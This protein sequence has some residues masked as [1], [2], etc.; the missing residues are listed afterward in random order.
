MGQDI[1]YLPYVTP[2]SAKIGWQ[3]CETAQKVNQ[4]NSRDSTNVVRAD[5][6]NQLRPSSSG[7][8][9]RPLPVCAPARPLSAALLPPAFCRAAC[10]T[11][12]HRPG[13]QAFR[14]KAC[15]H[16][17]AAALR[18]AA[19]PAAAVHPAEAVRAEHPPRHQ[20]LPVAPAVATAS[21][22]LEAAPATAA[23]NACRHA[24]CATAAADGA[25][26]AAAAS[27]AHVAAHGLAAV[28]AASVAGCASR[29]PLRRHGAPRWLSL[30][31]GASCRLFL[32][33]R[34]IAGLNVSAAVEAAQNARQR[35]AWPIA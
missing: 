34:D 20:Q 14:R 13:R 10:Q 7:A 9:C 26:A 24:A 3:R 12:C 1:S 2:T 5:A 25:A 28:A 27:L 21:C 22:S 29:L 6:I 17:R 19:A 11:A 8:S 16:R 30:A 23:S 31:A 18:P 32:D 4:E 15:R 33:Y 35:M